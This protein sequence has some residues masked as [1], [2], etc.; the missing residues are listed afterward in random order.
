[1]SD[2]RRR[3]EALQRP[4]AELDPA[5]RFSADH[6]TAVTRLACVLAELCASPRRPLIQMAGRLDDLMLALSMRNVRLIIGLQRGGAGD[7]EWVVA[8][9]VKEAR[10]ATD[11]ARDAEKAA[12]SVQDRLQCIDATT[13]AMDRESRAFDA[14]M[15]AFNLTPGF[16]RGEP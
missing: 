11:H 12:V 13:R 14:S 4:W 6:E 10:R 3:L 5:V 2:F 9:E 15:A 1:M 8:P 7:V 16:H